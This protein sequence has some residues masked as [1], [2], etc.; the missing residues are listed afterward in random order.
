ME[1]GNVGKVF[2]LLSVRENVK[3]PLKYES[4]GIKKIISILSAL[5]AMYNN[6]NICIVIDEMDSG[7]F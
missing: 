5:I 1:N 7:I 4:D 2:E 6:E 3:I